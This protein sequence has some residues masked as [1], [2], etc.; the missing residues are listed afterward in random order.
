MRRRHPRQGCA[1]TQPYAR[2]E[3]GG[4]KTWGGLQFAIEDLVHR[5]RPQLPLDP[6]AGSVLA[7]S[8]SDIQ[9]RRE[10]DRAA[11]LVA[12]SSGETPVAKAVAMNVS[13]PPMSRDE[14][15]AIVRR[16]S[17]ADARRLF[18]ELERLK[19]ME[20]LVREALLLPPGDAR[21]AGLREQLQDALEGRI[22]SR[23]AFGLDA[24]QRRDLFDTAATPA[25][26]APP[27]E[28]AAFAPGM[29]P[30]W[31]QSFPMPGDSVPSLPG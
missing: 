17:S 7:S 30:T 21:R 15:R 2:D 1:T 24:G 14:F 23:H 11:G 29:G 22:H 20:R 26:T 4:Q 27:P 6:P 18:Q 19:A 5:A 12:V 13:H 10:S 31:M 3:H 8:R 25:T 9:A 28:A 16:N